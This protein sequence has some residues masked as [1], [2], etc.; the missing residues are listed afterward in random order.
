MS[1]LSP[2]PNVIAIAPIRWELGW[3]DWPH[4]PNSLDCPRQE[5]GA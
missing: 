2:I 3:P 1:P 4:I 5:S